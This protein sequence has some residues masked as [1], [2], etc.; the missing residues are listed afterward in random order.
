MRIEFDG[1]FLAFNPLGMVLERISME[2]ESGWNAH[3][4][5]LDKDRPVVDAALAVLG[6]V[7]PDDYFRLGTRFE[8][9][10]TAYTCLTARAKPGDSF[11]P[12]VYLAA[13]PNPED[14]GRL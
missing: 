9:I 11:G 4:H 7:R 1:C 3:L 8:V 14:D 5:L 2:Q 12:G 6:D 10:E 13:S